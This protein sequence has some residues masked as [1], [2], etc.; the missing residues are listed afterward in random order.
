[1]WHEPSAFKE[2]GNKLKAKAA[3][4]IYSEEQKAIIMTIL[5][6]LKGIDLYAVR[7]SSP[8]EDLAGASFAGGYETILGVTAKTMEASIREAFV[9]C[10]DERVFFYKQQNG[11][12]TSVLRIAVVIQ[13][14]IASEV[15]GGVGFSLNP[16]N[17]CFDEAV[18]NANTGLGESVVSG[19]VT[20]DEIVV[21]KVT[22]DVLSKSIGSK[23]QAIILKKRW[24]YSNN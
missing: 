19:M 5:S 22:G 18:I 7:S 23:E 10:M 2:L 1:M 20:P 8:E 4:L 11:F 24:R 17:N 14:Q 21:D 6:E 16:L 15:S 3:D 13:S 12:D 9:S